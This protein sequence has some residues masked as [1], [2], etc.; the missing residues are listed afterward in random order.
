MSELNVTI[1]TPHG[2]VTL[3]FAQAMRLGEAIKELRERGAEP[4]TWHANECGCCVSVHG[5]DGGGWVI[6]PDG[7]ADYYAAGEHP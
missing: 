3:A 2:P 4:V 1:H 6:G 5:P 7:G